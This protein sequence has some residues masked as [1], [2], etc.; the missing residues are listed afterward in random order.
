ANRCKTGTERPMREAG[1]PFERGERARTIGSTGR[2]FDDVELTID[3]TQFRDDIVDDRRPDWQLA[4]CRA[5]PRFELFD[6]ILGSSPGCLGC[7]P[8][9]ERVVMRLDLALVAS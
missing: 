2:P 5:E 1:A 7:G 4:Q 9:A 6:P 3:L 8:V